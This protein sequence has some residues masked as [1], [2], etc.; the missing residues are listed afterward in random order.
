MLSKAELIEQLKALG[1][2][3]GMDLLVHSSLRRVG[4]VEGGADTI[5]DALQEVLGPEGT[6]MMST[7]SGN[8]GPE[9]TVFHVAHTASTVGV[10]SNVFRKRPAAIRSLHPVHSIAAM[11]PKAKFFTE[12][13]LEARTPWSPESPYGKLMRNNGFILF[14]GADLQANTCIHAIEIEARVPGLHRRETTRLQVIDYDGT[15]RET[16][17]HWHAP[18]RS[19]YNDL[20]HIVERAGGLTYGRVGDGISR[21]VDAAILRETLLPIFR[22]TPELG[23]ARLTDSQFIW[24]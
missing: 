21:F 11:G 16:D 1:L 2:K 17:H 4:P 12:G 6:L 10:L 22:E 18:K 13:H 7:V 20:E 9:Q 15:L 23:I 19:R 24:E 5:I 14:L 8:V 3:P